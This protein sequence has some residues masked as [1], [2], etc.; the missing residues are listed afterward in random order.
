MCTGWWWWCTVHWPDFRFCENISSWSASP[1]MD[2]GGFIILTLVFFFRSSCFETERVWAR[3]QQWRNFFLSYFSIFWGVH[4]DCSTHICP[5]VAS[6]QS[7]FFNIRTKKKGPTWNFLNRA[8]HY[9]WSWLCAPGIHAEF[10]PMIPIVFISIKI[11]F[12]III[13]GQV[14]YL[15]SAIADKVRHISSW[16]DEKSFHSFYKKDM[17]SSCLLYNH[18]YEKLIFFFFFFSLAVCCLVL[19]FPVG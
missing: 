12:L 1:Y 7:F 8:A 5:A 6:R 3:N 4:H 16:I 10:A 19:P 2:N 14:L 13:I 18:R 15:F 17:K 11:T 9:C